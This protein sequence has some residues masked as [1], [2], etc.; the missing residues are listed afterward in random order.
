M[1]SGVIWR[2]FREWR[3]LQYWE[4]GLAGGPYTRTASKRGGRGGVLVA[5]GNFPPWF[6]KPKEAAGEQLGGKAQAQCF[7]C[8]EKGPF[9]R[10]CSS[11]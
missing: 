4:P 5:K 9:A 3:F 11:K 8:M 6:E 7:K 1:L 10:Y 2:A